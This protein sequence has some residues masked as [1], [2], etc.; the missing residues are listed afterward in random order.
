MGGCWIA[1]ETRGMLVSQEFVNNE[2]K[3]LMGF[4]LVYKSNIYK[5][6]EAYSKVIDI[7]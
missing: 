3:C 5:E 2:K 1:V 4:I 6:E 7:C